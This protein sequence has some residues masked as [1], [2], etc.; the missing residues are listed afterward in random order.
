MRERYDIV[1]TLER[2]KRG[3]Y[4]VR[5]ANNDQNDGLIEVVV[6]WSVDAST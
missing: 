2:G 3:R 6:D 5:N 4:G 1:D